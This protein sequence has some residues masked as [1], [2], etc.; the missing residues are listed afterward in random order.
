VSSQPSRINE[1][2]EATKRVITDIAKKPINML[3][4]ASA[5]Q[6]LQRKHQ[7]DM[8]TNEYWTSLLSNLQSDAS[9][10]DI[11]CIRDVAAVL[12]QLGPADVQNA[13][14]SLLTGEDQLFTAVGIQ[15]P[16]SN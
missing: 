10:K 2:I 8:H 16:S 15:G 7:N 14:R 3:E 5:R 9:N 1:A 6:H 4:I 11:T 13:W 12:Q